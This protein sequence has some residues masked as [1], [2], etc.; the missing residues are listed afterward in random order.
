MI[1]THEYTSVCEIYGTF[2]R[3]ISSQHTVLLEIKLL[4][5]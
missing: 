5:L 2:R 1:E 4:K 3:K